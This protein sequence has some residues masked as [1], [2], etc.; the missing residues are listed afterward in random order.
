VRLRETQNVR[1]RER[2]IE[3]QKDIAID[4]DIMDRQR[5][6]ETDRVRD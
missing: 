4:R 1:V 6:T 3:R 2:N 5:L